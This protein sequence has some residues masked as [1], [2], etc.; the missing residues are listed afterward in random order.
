MIRIIC[1]GACLVSALPAA[2]PTET[3]EQHN[4]R[5]K[6]WREATFG[7][8]IHWGIYSVP[9]GTYDGK[10]IPNIG[11]WIM[12]NGKI[13]VARLRRRHF[14]REDISGMKAADTTSSRA[15]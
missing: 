6:W 5:M 8:F 3:K 15:R 14:N 10:Q 9:A 4:A 2:A 12:N 7:L 11:Q 13:P 1:A